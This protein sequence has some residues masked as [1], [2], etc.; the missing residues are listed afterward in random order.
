VI[1][2]SCGEYETTGDDLADVRSASCLG[3]DSGVLLVSASKAA[4]EKLNRCACLEVACSACASSDESGLVDAG[5]TGEVILITV[6][7]GR[8]S[9]TFR[10]DYHYSWIRNN[11][12][13]IST[14][15]KSSLRDE[16]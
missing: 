15:N 3:E 10:V 9:G 2:A 5:V 6:I 13:P 12:V 7:L 11:N 4:T 8:R 14:A 1:R 16:D